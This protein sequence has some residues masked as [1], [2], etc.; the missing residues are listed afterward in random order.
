MQHE[1]SVQMMMRDYAKCIPS[2]DRWTNPAAVN[3]S[4]GRPSEGPAERYW[5]ENGE[6]AGHKTKNP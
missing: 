6:P 2:V 3:A 5:C 4:I 1:H